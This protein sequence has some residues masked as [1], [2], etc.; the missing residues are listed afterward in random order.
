M[1]AARNIINLKRIILVISPGLRSKLKPENNRLPR[2][3]KN[4]SWINSM[5]NIVTGKGKGPTFAVNA[6]NP[7]KSSENRR[8]AR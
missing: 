5:Q 4:S 2:Y 1:Q 8:K 6:V 7:T 3:T